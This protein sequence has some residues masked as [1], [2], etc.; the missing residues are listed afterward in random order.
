MDLINIEL[1]KPST[2]SRGFILD[3][4][5]EYTSFWA[6]AIVSNRIYTPKVGCR[7]FNR[8]IEIQQTEEEW[9]FFTKGIM[10][11]PEDLLITSEFDRYLITKPKPP[12][13]DGEEEPPEEEKPVPLLESNLVKVVWKESVIPLI[14]HITLQ[15]NPLHYL[16]IKN[17]YQSPQ[18]CLE[19]LSLSLYSIPLAKKIDG[20]EK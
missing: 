18:E 10:Q 6:K 17:A 4:P 20:N 19:S 15:M 2:Q 16:K 5:I 1:K 14:E 9:A 11:K 13:E 8:V 7:F 12:P 3:L